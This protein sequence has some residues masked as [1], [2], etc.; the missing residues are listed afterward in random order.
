MSGIGSCVEGVAVGSINDV[1]EAFRRA[2][3]NYDRGALFERL[4]LRYFQ[5]D[6]ALAQQYEQVWLWS[7]WPDRKGK[8]DTGI[9]LVARELVGQLA[10]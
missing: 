3:T 2:P 5:L 4:M 1:M 6:P 7:D 10:E 9:D 8:P